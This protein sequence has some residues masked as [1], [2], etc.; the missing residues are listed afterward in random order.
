MK[1]RI[2]AINPGSTSTKIAVYEDKTCILRESIAHTKGDL[3]QFHDLYEQIPFRLQ[4][5]CAHMAKFGI[6]QESLSAAVGRG[7]LIAPVAS[8]TYRVDDAMILDL[9]HS[10][11]MHASN[12]GALLAWRIASE[13]DKPAFI[14]DP[15]TVD[16]RDPKARI[17]GLKGV[18]RTSVFHA[19]NQKAVARKTADLLHKRYEELNLV[20]AHLGGGFSVGAHQHGRVIDASNALEGEGPFSPDR[21]G[22]VPILRLLEFL[23]HNHIESQAEIQRLL[24]NAGGFVSY[25]GTNDL[26]LLQKREDEGDQYVADILDAYVYQV[27]K[28]IGAYAAVLKGDMDAV[29]LTGGIAHSQRIITAV[30]AYISFLG[31]VYVWPGE[32]EMEALALGALRVMQGEE[33]AK[34]Y[35]TEKRKMMQT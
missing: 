14:V 17:S 8:G 33:E 9:K 4:I 21:S 15:V 12:L 24:L 27:A 18:E 34:H 35:A 32:D 2:L 10:E 5:I 19:L 29:V 6:A 28:E 30:Q 7:G 25:F 26:L 16:E 31:P 1:D 20:V 22:A 23:H 3:E 11:R 13:M